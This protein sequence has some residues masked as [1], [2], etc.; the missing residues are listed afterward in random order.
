MKDRERGKSGDLPIRIG[1]RELEYENPYQKVFRVA[2]DF[3]DHS[4]EIFVNDFGPR[5]GVVI[6]RGDDL[7]LVR[8]YRLLIDGFSLEIPGGGVDEGE[9]PEQAA[10][11]EAREETGIHCLTLAPLLFFH[12]GLDTCDNPGH[13]F[14]CEEFEEDAD[15]DAGNQTEI[16]GHQW[17]PLDECLEMVFDSRIADSLTI[18]GVLAFSAKRQRG[19]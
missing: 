12:P 8:Q 18:S 1:D 16:V 15:F 14:S 4:K 9:S 19:A 17:V 7:L 6:A 3:E 2:V 10:V 13:L 5:V 11:R